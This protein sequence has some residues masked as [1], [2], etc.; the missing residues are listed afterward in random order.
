MMNMFYYACDEAALSGNENPAEVPANDAIPA[1][2][3]EVDSPNAAQEVQETESRQETAAQLPETPRLSNLDW[4]VMELR[5][6]EQE[7]KEL[8]PDF[9]L[10]RE[11]RANPR[12]LKLTAPGS[13]LTLAEALT[14]VHLPRLMAMRE[15]RLA[16]QLREGLA[17]SIMSGCYRPPLLSGSAAAEAAAPMDRE[18]LKERI[19]GGEKIRP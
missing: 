14:T 4:H 17:K 1:A 11:L 10:Q 3:A 16:R 19:R 15:E 13:P 5:R 2:A 18:K 9:D 12:L 7:L 6:Q 8:I